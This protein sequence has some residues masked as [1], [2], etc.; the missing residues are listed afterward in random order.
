MQFRSVPWPTISDAVS[1]IA[2]R[3]VRGVLGIGVAWGALWSVIL[4]LLLLFARLVPGGKAPIAVWPG[5]IAGFL[6]GVA[7]GV[8]LAYAE[9]GKTIRSISMDR[10]A[11]WGALASVIFPLLTW[12]MQHALV[13]CPIGALL[14]MGSLALAQ[15]TVIRGAEPTAGVFLQHYARALIRDAVAPTK[16]PAS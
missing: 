16:E 1:S 8:L 3:K 9:R 12:Q 15:R 6:S 4:V 14:A 10:A 13:S 11:L 2:H 7:F 5:A